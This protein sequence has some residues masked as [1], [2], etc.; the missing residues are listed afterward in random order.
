MK[1]NAFLLISSIVLVFLMA[2]CNGNVTPTETIPLATTDSI[3][4]EGHFVPN[5]NLTLTFLA[6]GKVSEVLVEKG[7]RVTNGQVLV[8]L[9]DSQQAAAA[10]AGAKLELLAAQQLNDTLLRTADL[11][12]AQALLAY[13]SAQKTKLETQLMWDRLDLKGIE[14]SIDNARKEVDS[15]KTDLDTAQQE[16]DKNKNLPVDD[17]ERTNAESKLKTAQTN[18]DEALRLLLIQ[19][20]RR[21]LP[22]AALD[23]AIGVETEA[24]RAYV[25]LKD[26]PFSE[27][28]MLAKARLENATAQVAAAQNALDNYELISPFDGTVADINVTVN[29]LVGPETW[30]VIVIDDSQWFVDTSDLTEYDVVQ[31]KTGDTAKITIDALPEVKMTGV[32]DEI[33]MAPKSQAGDILYTVRLRVDNP[34]PLLKWGMTMEVTFPVV[35]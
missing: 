21:D 6:R 34:D 3:V 9:G 20:N 2:G 26:G 35:K 10:L 15:R 8:K 12:K 31:I 28:I 1:N 33:A 22:K 19:T 18:Y 25:S 23:S 7:D 4:V 11:E 29:Q 27:K 30:A 5:E 13:T 17:F 32:V 24:R 14:T 16:F